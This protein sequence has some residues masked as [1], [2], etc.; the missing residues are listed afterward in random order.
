[1]KKTVCRLTVGLSLL[2][3]LLL[4]SCGSSKNV[5]YLMNAD[6][7]PDNPGVLYDARIMPKDILTIVVNTLNPAAAQQFNL[8]A[9]G[10]MTQSNASLTSQPTLQ[11]YLVDNDGNINSP[12]SAHCMW[13]DSPS[14]RPNSLSSTRSAHTWQSQR[15]QSLPSGC[16]VTP[17]Q[18]LA[19]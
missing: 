18:C 12:S 13:Q 3:V 17:S 7:L 14:L 8:T 19:R 15:S 5:P 11:G 16:R 4:T 6:S 2:A 1:M 10:V 9:S